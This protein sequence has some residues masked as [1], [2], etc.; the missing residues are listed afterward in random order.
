MSSIIKVDKIQLSDGSIPSVTDLGV[1][2]D[3][4]N[5]LPSGSVVQT[6]SFYYTG[7]TQ[8]SS[9]STPVGILAGSITPTAS[10]NHFI[11]RSNMRCSHNPN[12]S[13]YFIMNING[14][15]DYNSSGR[16]YPSAGGSIYMEGYGNSH[17]SNAQI[18]E[19]TSEYMYTHNSAA[20]F[21][22]TMEGYLQGGTAYM[23]YAYSY[24]DAARGRPLSSLIIQEIKA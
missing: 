17:S 9:A 24:D 22:V 13:L 14:N 16:G 18:N 12:Q 21:T 8:W 7:T 19:Y 6:K 10:G 4:Y 20:A 2:L 23:N 5:N 15:R 11:I 3:L 1:N